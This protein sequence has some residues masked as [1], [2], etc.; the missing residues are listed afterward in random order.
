MSS[1][2]VR[3]FRRADRE[4]VTRLVN[5]HIAAV[6]PGISVSVNTVLAQF[7]REPGE[8]I[9]DPWVIE[10]T[11]LVAEQRQAVAAAAYLLRYGKQSRVDEHFRDVGE[12]RWLLFWPDRP[13]WPDSARPVKRCSP[14][15]WHNSNA[16]ASAGKSPTA[17]SP[18]RSS[19]AFRRNGRTSVRPSR[20][21][22]S[23]TRGASRS[24]SSPT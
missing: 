14:H 7:E 8:F 13:F 6:V 5:A 16:G 4:Q 15:A 22:A 10:R 18:R 17:P 11:A 1:I 2:E 12:I 19:T 9:V 24:S 3:P 23:G 20:G 21:P